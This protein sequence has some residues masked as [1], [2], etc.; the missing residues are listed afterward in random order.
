MNLILRISFMVALIFLLG[1]STATY[2]QRCGGDLRYILRDGK[3]EMID[4]EKI[5]VRYITY[6]VGRIGSNPNDLIGRQVLDESMPESGVEVESAR[7]IK[8]LYLKSG[9]GL[10]LVE[11]ELEHENR[12]MALRFH[13]IPAETNFLVDSVPFRRGTYEIDF[14]G[15]MSLKS[16][17]LNR[18]GLRGKEGKYF[19]HS[20]AKAGYLVSADNWIKAR[21]KKP[22]I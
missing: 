7:S 5:S 3:G 12:V 13:N 15:D 1:G 16:V 17:K 20:S 2:A 8:I 18:D 9:C 4:T 6:G 11:V 10:R 21:T 14:K 22:R 19:L